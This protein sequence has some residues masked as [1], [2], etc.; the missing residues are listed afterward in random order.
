MPLKIM[1]VDSSPA[2]CKTVQRFLSSQPGISLVEAAVDAAH[3]LEMAGDIQPDLVLLEKNFKHADSFILCRMLKR[4]VPGIKVILTILFDYQSQSYDTNFDGII[5]KENFGTN[6][7][8]LLR[9]LYNPEA[10][11]QNKREIIITKNK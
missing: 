1:A 9:S 10:K 3:L 11:F 4:Q 5:D 8:P 7:L 6:F 2:F